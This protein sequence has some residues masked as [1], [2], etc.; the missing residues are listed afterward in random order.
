MIV[1][2]KRKLINKIKN[3]TLIKRELYYP[4]VED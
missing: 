3:Y 1:S 4:I 2:N